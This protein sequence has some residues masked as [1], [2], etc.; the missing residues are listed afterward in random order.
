MIKLQNVFKFYKIVKLEDYFVVKVLLS[1]V[2][3]FVKI[4]ILEISKK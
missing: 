3:K 4:E 1:V 2:L